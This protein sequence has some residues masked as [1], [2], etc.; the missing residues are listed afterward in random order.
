MPNLLSP[1]AER[2]VG[3]V[4]RAV[5]FQLEA[6]G[7]VVGERDVD[8]EAQTIAVALQRVVAAEAVAV[9]VA[10]GREA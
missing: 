4:V 9:V 3:A 1:F 7:E 10:I 2:L 6:A 5:G 8:A